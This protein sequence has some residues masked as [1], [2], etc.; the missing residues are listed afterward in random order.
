MWMLV[1]C[2]L[3]AVAALCHGQCGTKERV[4]EC[5]PQAEVCEF[6]LEIEELQTFTSYKLP[7]NPAQVIPRLGGATYYLSRGKYIRSRSVAEE[8]EGCLLSEASSEEEFISNGCTVPTTVDGETFRAFVGVNGFTP[9]PTLIAHENQIIGINVT[10]NLL[11]EVTS[12]HWHGIHQRQTPWMDGIGFV[13]QAPIQPG[14]TFRYIFLASPSGTHWYHSHMGAQRTDGLLGALIVRESEAKENRARELL[15]ELLPGIETF[16]DEPGNHTVIIMDWQQEPSIGLFAKFQS[17][18]GFYTQKVM[19]KVPTKSESFYTA[20]KST[21]GAE[22]GTIPFW[23]GLINGKGRHTAYTD[24]VS[25]ENSVLRV[26][27]VQQG[28]LYRFRVI[29]VQGIFAYR[30]S[31]DEHKLIV[32]ATDG[33]FIEPDTVDY[34]IVHSG[35]RY[36]FILNT[37]SDE[38]NVLN[39]WIRVE[40]IEANGSGF[41]DHNTEA[42]LHYDGAPVPNP[43]TNYSEVTSERRICSP[44][45]KCVAANCPFKEFP[46]SYGIDCIHVHQF[47]SLEDP[48]SEELP[49]LNA[50]CSDCVHFFN[51]GFEGKGRTSAINAR[52]FKLPTTPYQ[53]YPEQYRID[54]ENQK[55]CQECKHEED[56]GEPSPECACSH[57]RVLSKDLEHTDPYKSHEP[58]IQMIISSIG[59]SSLESFRNFSH[60]VHI[61][62]HYFYVLHVE[63][64]HTIDG[65]LNRS[66]SDIACDNSACSEPR[67]RVEKNLS[68]YEGDPVPGKDAFYIRSKTVRKDT[69]IIPA[70]GYAIVYLRANNPGY[71]LLHCHIEPHQLGGMA[72]ILREYGSHPPPPAGINKCGDFSWTVSDFRRSL[73][74]TGENS[75]GESYISLHIAW[76]TVLSFLSLM[77]LLLAVVVGVVAI[78][79]YRHRRGYKR[80]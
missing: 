37:T 22:V 35:E 68:E 61:H 51:F 49:T 16:S 58:T 76:I 70:G 7:K 57:V 53:S 75:S 24:A 11:T 12:I 27:E 1:V 59:N 56:T 33:N 66:S 46:A 71:W 32:V 38:D 52:N 6:T 44:D 26:F 54:V 60:P 63:H 80:V 69:V 47:R 4:C 31:I 8:E 14:A 40:T 2:C 48:E 41:L 65:V 21:D 45:N 28:N 78:Y 74:Y 3:S 17:S 34:I 13:S 23:S 43:A 5:D 50:E 36:D 62:G 64:G 42:I 55:T 67:W 77:F 79:N 73:A 72:V 20:T 19:E 25:Y 30:F 10:N 39:Y 9:G 15:G 18:L 29:G